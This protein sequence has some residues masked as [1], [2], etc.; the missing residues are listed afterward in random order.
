MAKY[1]ES[2]GAG[3][4]DHSPNGMR[5][6]NSPSSASVASRLYSNGQRSSRRTSLGSEPELIN[7][8]D[9]EVY[10]EFNDI[11]TQVS[12]L[13]HRMNAM[14]ES[15]MLSSEERSRLRTENAVLTQRVHMLEEQQQSTEQ[16]WREKLEEE[17]ARKRNE[18]ARMDRETDL[19]ISNWQLK[20][21]ALETTSEMNKKERD[22]YYDE[23]TQLQAKF[24]ELK[25]ELAFTQS[26]CNSLEEEK[27]AL[28]REFDRFREDAH[29]DLENSSELV[30]ELTR[31]TNELRQKSFPVPRQG[32]LADQIVM[33]EDE[34]ERLRLENKSFREQNDELQAQLLHDSVEKGRCLL[35][36]GLPSLAEELNGKDSTELMNALKEQEPGTPSSQRQRQAGG[37]SLP[38]TP[39]PTDASVASRLYA[40]LPRPTEWTFFK[41][42]HPQQPPSP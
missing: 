37:G 4:V 11:S 35:A 5:F 20:Y 1:F 18:Q 32:S 6:S 28:Q 33:L 14:E 22:R 27:K 34:I 36:D 24:S 30:E 42:N 21:E 12:S 2:L 29:N 26:S 31:Q 9:S 39:P 3:E 25:D 40:Y 8:S 15:Q 10:S 41:R 19:K 17:K 13:S 16:Q 23:L 38:T 7:L